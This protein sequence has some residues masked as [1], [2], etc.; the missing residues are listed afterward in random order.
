MGEGGLREGGG[1]KGVWRA[2]VAG[3]PM[4][5]THSLLNKQCV[6]QNHAVLIFSTCILSTDFWL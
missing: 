3:G 5:I 4:S 6:S 2:V 1:R